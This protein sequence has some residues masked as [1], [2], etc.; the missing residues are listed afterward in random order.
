MA[1][2]SRFNQPTN[3]DQ[4]PVQ[5]AT[6]NPTA[7][8][9][10]QG[11]ANADNDQPETNP[12]PG[13]SRPAGNSAVTGPTSALTS[14]LK[15]QGIR[16][17]QVNRFTPLRPPQASTSTAIPE[18]DEGTHDQPDEE[19]DPDSDDLDGKPD[20]KIKPKVTT[21]EAT[22]STSKA[23]APSLSKKNEDQPWEPSKPKPGKYADRK[24]G[25][26][27]TCAECGKRF[28][29]TRTTVRAPGQNGQ[30]CDGCAQEVAKNPMSKQVN[31]TPAPAAKKRKTT[32]NQVVRQPWS[33]SSIQTLQMACITIIARNTESIEELGHVGSVN[34]EKICQI[35]CKH[36]E[37]TSEN[38]PLFVDAT[39]SDLKLFDCIN[40]REPHLQSIAYFCPRLEKLTLNLCGHMTG[41]VLKTY[42]E[43]LPRLRELELFGPYL[44]R[45]E[46]WLKAFE[47][48]SQP[49]LIR[50]QQLHG[51]DQEEMTVE[52]DDDDGDD[53]KNKV[54]FIQ[55]PLIK[56]FRLKQSPRFDL[57][58][59]KALVTSCPNLTSLR[60]VDIGLLNDQ[61]LDVIAHAGLTQIKDLSIANAGIHNGATG[62][63]L[64]D[65]A[66]S[67]LLKSVGTTVE[68]LDISQNK[69]LT[70]AVLDSIQQFCSQ[71]TYLDLN[72][73]KELSTKGVQALFVQFKQSGAPG[74]KHL[75]LSRCIK[76][77]NEALSSI[78]DHS[79]RTL[80]MLDLNSV[81]ELR[82][83]A[84]ERLAKETIHLEWLDVS[85]VRDVDDFIIK[86]FLD[87]MKHLKSLLVYGNNRVSDLC[88]T[89][90]G[91][92]I[93][94]QERSIVVT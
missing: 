10:D 6:S 30:L 74:L 19:S 1:R 24:P 13:P 84:L 59:V 34:L 64:T 94:G 12:T 83:E 42:V 43:K 4:N 44:I 8:P 28:T 63:A 22:A 53:D 76:I 32:K 50:P 26:I 3:T 21:K 15:E 68:R 16:P 67:N 93:K 11:D 81:D 48:W 23:A 33:E 36:R 49:R 18:V 14:F 41:D 35:V 31:P 66:V 29:V 79:A 37:L 73:L 57:A 45:K 65:A 38:L 72:G 80:Q 86:A 77:G 47:I 75:N 70:D 20:R 40:L 54:E 25:L 89:R 82:A 27:T 71:L 55:A 69:K 61:S 87:H 9:S 58:C 7:P 90:K 60:L 62:E 17:R 52:E 2:P 51:A 5:A 88:P 56:G 92:A 91:V 46:A 39:H 85:F 78:L